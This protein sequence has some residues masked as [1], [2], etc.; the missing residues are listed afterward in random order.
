MVA[1]AH[2]SEKNRR[3]GICDN[4]ICGHW[5]GQVGDKVTKGQVVCIVEAMKLMNE[6]EVSFT[7]QW[8][9]KITDASSTAYDAL[10]D[11]LQNMLIEAFCGCSV[12]LPHLIL[13]N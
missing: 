6:I 10:F 1:I 4:E 7:Q 5:S 8:L 2:N 3:C 13:L 9:E 11:I 12:L